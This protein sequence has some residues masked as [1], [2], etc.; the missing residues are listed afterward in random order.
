M[1]NPNLN[2]QKQP[3]VL[4]ILDGFGFSSDHSYNAIYEAKK[5]NFDHLVALYPHTLLEASGTAVGLPAHTIGNSEVGHLTIGAGR[6]IPQ[7][8]LRIDQEI[9]QGTLENN[10]I[11]LNN[12]K[13]LQENKGRLHIMGLLSD[14]G[15]HSKQEHLYGFLQAAK[16]YGISSVFIHAFLD[17]RD[18]P[19]KSAEIYL[20]QLTQKIEF[21]NI[22]TLGSLHGRFYAMDRDH[23]WQRT[24]QTYN[25]LTSKQEIQFQTW[26]DAI[27]FYYAQN[28]TDEFIPPTQLTAESVIVPHDGIIFFNVRPDRARQVTAS[29]VDPHFEKFP[30]KKTPLSFFITPVSYDKNLQ[31]QCLLEEKQVT[32]TLNETL[33]KA[34]KS[35]F[36]IAETEKYAH[37]TYFFNGGKEDLL[38]CETRIL[39]PSLPLRNYKDHPEMSAQKI[40]TAVV[41]SLEHNPHDFYLINYANADMVGHSGDFDATIKAI[42]C[43]DIQLGILYHEVVQKLGGT[44]YITGDHGNAE[45]MFDFKSKQPKTA[46]TTNSVYFIMIRNGLENK[47]LP[48]TIKGLADIAPCILHEMGIAIPSEMHDFYSK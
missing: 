31:T 2:L 35:I 43:L 19:P 25:V 17:G 33:C 15:V 24:E 47:P 16:K 5:P 3:T 11:L 1:S 8:S 13:K 21:L 6:I 44:L 26:Q 4:V 39:I 36:A 12:F 10:P 30:I 32:N 37:I 42:E 40:T 20:T 9:A 23:N 45:Q 48:C 18:V 27:S 22:G 29:F 46:H 14:G 38:P 7:P 34:G 28:I 41:N